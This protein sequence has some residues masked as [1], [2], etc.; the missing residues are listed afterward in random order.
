M[1]RAMWMALALPAAAQEQDPLDALVSTLRTAPALEVN[2]WARTPML[3]N[4]TSID[5]D[6]RGRVWV[7]EAVNYRDF[8][9]QDDKTTW[10]AGGDRIVILEDTTGDGRADSSR[11]FVQD[12]DLV[13]P[14]GVAVVGDEVIV[15]CSPNLIVYTRGPEDE[16][17]DKR[18]LLTG[19][20]GLDHDHSLHAAQ[21]GPDGRYLFN[22]GN[23]G[24][25]L[26][27]DAAGWN[28]RAGSWFTGGSPHNKENTPGL[29]SDDGRVWHGGVAL[30]V[31]TDG[32][33]LEVVGHGFRNAVGTCVDSYGE[34]WMNDNDDTRSC[35]TT[36]LLP[37]GDCGYDSKDG[38]RSWRADMRPGQS[39]RTAHWRQDDP[40]VI[41]SGHVYGNGA[42]TGI[43]WLEGFG[44]GNEYAGGLLLSCEA[45]QN[46]VWG[47]RRAP[48]G[49]GYEL[50][51]FVFL[52]TTSD[53]D[54]D[55]VWSAR[56]ADPARWFRPS[57]VAVG[58]DGA[59]YVSDWFDPVVGGHQ[60]DDDLA[61]GA[62]YRVVRE[63]TS[64]TSPN[65][66]DVFDRLRSPAPNV[67]AAAIEELVE[68]GERVV[69]ALQEI[70]DGLRESPELAAR[71]A[72][73]AGRMRA[74][75]GHLLCL[76]LTRHVDPELRATAWRALGAG[77]YDVGIHDS[78][79]A[80]DVSTLVRRDLALS[81]RDRPWETRRATWLALAS[82]YRPDPWMLEA[83]G[84]GAEGHELLA[85]ASLA[86]S[87]VDQDPLAW[88][89]GLV[90][91]ARR[92]HAPATVPGM[93]AR[94][95]APELPRAERRRAIDALGFTGPVAAG[96]MLVRVLAEGPEDLRPLARWWLEEGAG[97]A[98]AHLAPARP[99]R[100]PGLA[101]F[102]SGV[103]HSGAV[104]L[105]LDLTGARKLWLVAD[106]GG[107]GNSC[108]WADWLDGRLV[109]AD[110]TSVRLEQHGWSLGEVGWGALNRDKDCK[111]GPLA[112]GGEVYE[113]GIGTHA[114][115][116]LAFD[117]KGDF[118]RLTVRAAMDDGDFDAAQR[119]SS[120]RFLAYH[121]GPPD[122]VRLARLRSALLEGDQ[123]IQARVDAARALALD[124]TG[125]HVL[126][127]LAQ[128]GALPA[129]VLDA[130][131]AEMLAHGDLAVR[132]LAAGVFG[133]GA[134]ASVAIEAA[135]QGD[136][137]RGAQ[138]FFEAEAAC[139][140]CHAVDGRGGAV[141]PDLSAVGGKYGPAELL[142]QIL[143]PS[144]VILTGFETC[145]VQTTDGLVHAGF[146]RG[147]GDEVV[148]E[149]AQGRRVSI[150][151][152]EVA[153]RRQSERSTMPDNVA[154][155]LSAQDLADLM[156]F[157]T[158]LR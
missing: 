6:E 135:A 128:E 67:W 102:D 84:Q 46:V 152:D 137:D 38:A 138:I 154:L 27:E 90:D 54:P 42:P 41:P 29:V 155:G 156:A 79:R 144:A 1:R 125:G 30:K 99:A 145:V 119:R 81:L 15:S 117:L 65:L 142:Q 61:T 76:K 116:V 124:A 106:D 118:V 45:G 87:W 9:N 63:G 83:L 153:V 85:W 139:S 20:G 23:A 71:V 121:D 7:A 36:F 148:L 111:G 51:P 35:R 149:D 40:G 28:L 12:E 150:P 157:L 82:A 89:P 37:H 88:S 132:A 107:D 74:R 158:R 131:A 52:G 56:K 31:G 114:P 136:P 17:L 78:Q 43:G 57:D 96:E 13:S 134:V 112:V 24:P 86:D 32:R 60:M 91:L 72:W 104:D 10:R 64:P 4:P 2:V 47:Y 103:L 77:P 127:A 108:D 109:R 21:L 98:F 70:L 16:V 68:Q 33:G 94:A 5:V 143:E 113:H 123:P 129:P 147:D 14:M 11:V 22:V 26:V 48:A 34:L 59:V 146:L 110:G 44:L 58:T 126:V 105:S 39:V 92:L 66:A 101:R 80:Q 115:S 55:Y 50:E 122:R 62:I 25:H 140:R 73:A 97:G 8:N 100:F 151:S 93:G 49:A 53:P 130:V 18:V 141:G 75:A 69:P 133:E 3:S 120:V 95:L 19:F